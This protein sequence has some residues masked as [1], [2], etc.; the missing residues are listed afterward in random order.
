MTATATLLLVLL[1]GVVAQDSTATTMFVPSNA[2]SSSLS[3]PDTLPQRCDANC[4]PQG[5]G[6]A[7]LR[8][9][10]TQVQPNDQIVNSTLNALCCLPFIFFC[11]SCFQTIETACTLQFRDLSLACE[12]A[13]RVP[14]YT[15]VEGDSCFYID[16]AWRSR[17]DV[18]VAAL[19]IVAILIELK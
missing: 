16:D 1:V 10:I 13:L 7:C 14:S 5:A 4:L 3:S 2:S 19:A 17:L 18:L 15:P 9:N 12:Q 8:C 11:F 6:A